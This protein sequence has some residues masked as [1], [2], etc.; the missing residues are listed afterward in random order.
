MFFRSLPICEGWNVDR[1]VNWELCLSAPSSP[2]RP[3]AAPVL[4][5]QPHRSACRSP[6]ASYPHSWTRPRDT[7]TP[8]LGAGTLSPHVDWLGKLPG[9]LEYSYEGKVLVHSSTTRTES[10]LLVLNLR[11]DQRSE[12][13]FQYPGDIEEQPRQPNNVQH[14]QHL[15][16]DL[17]HQGATKELFDNL[18]G[19]CQGYWCDT[20]PSLQALPPLEG[21]C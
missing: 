3:A 6:A 19:L 12:P 18:S 13:T 17:I 1:P 10:A 20:P 7:W 4:L 9:P 21:T 15:R 14:L 16:A 2:R 5:L 11:F 8:S